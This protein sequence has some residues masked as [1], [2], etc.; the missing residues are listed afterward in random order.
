MLYNDLIQD[1]YTRMYMMQTAEYTLLSDAAGYGHP[2]AC[3]TVMP[4]P[5]LMQREALYT[6][7]FDKYATCLRMYVQYAS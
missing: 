2:I 4:H 6:Y 7:N 1:H 5:L 3:P